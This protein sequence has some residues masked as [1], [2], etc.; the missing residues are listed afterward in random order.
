MYT[1]TLDP[2]LN[3]LMTSGNPILDF[4]LDIYFLFILSLLNINFLNFGVKMLFLTNIFF[5]ISL[6]IAIEEART[7]E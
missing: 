4:N 1:S 7:P 5:E 6:S 2:S 3:G